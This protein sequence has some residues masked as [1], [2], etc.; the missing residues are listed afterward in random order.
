MSSILKKLKVEKSDGMAG[1]GADQEALRDEL[2][3]SDSSALKGSAAGSGNE[4]GHGKGQELDRAPNTAGG[5]SF[6][7]TSMVPRHTS[8]TLNKVDPRIGYDSDEI[9]Q[10]NL[11]QYEAKYGK[12]SDVSDGHLRGRGM[13]GESAASWELFDCPRA[14]RLLR[15][16]DRMKTVIPGGRHGSVTDL[17]ECRYWA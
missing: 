12:P 2:E 3:A 8:E 10:E 4:M 17:L 15:I 14:P 5:P 1:I 9:R 11:E 7:R 16:V 6:G 13:A